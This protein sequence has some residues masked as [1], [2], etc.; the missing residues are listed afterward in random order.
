MIDGRP[1]YSMYHKIIREEG[2]RTAEG[3]QRNGD[4]ILIFVS[5]HL[6]PCYCVVQLEYIDWFILGHYRCASCGHNP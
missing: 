2:N 5:P 4:G 1:I 3:I 6:P